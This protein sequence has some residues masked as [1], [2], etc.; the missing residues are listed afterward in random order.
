M[1]KK[2]WL[3]QKCNS[4][5]LRG[6][7][8]ARRSVA[9]LVAALRRHENKQVSDESA[10]RPSAIP[11]C[12]HFFLLI[13]LTKNHF[14][15]MFKNAYRIIEKSTFLILE[16]SQRLYPNPKKASKTNDPRALPQTP[17]NFKKASKTNEKS[18]FL[19]P[20]TS[21]RLYPILPEFPKSF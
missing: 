20:E 8:Y 19:T 10:A 4:A 7:F 18:T 3:A 21:P 15:N 6:R 17:S 9:E 11:P 13:K 5:T 2:G 12:N 1:R 16:A 14:L